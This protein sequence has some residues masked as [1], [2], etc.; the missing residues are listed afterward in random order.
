MPLTILHCK[1]VIWPQKSEV[2]RL[3]SAFLFQHVRTLICDTVFKNIV[4]TEGGKNGVVTL[5]RPTQLQRAKPTRCPVSYLDRSPQQLW[6]IDNRPGM[7][8][9]FIQGLV[10]LCHRV[11]DLNMPT[12]ERHNMAKDNDNCSAD[13]G[14]GTEVTHVI[15]SRSV[16]PDWLWGKGCVCTVRRKTP[17]DALKPAQSSEERRFWN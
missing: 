11:A 17:Q 12:L 9:K 14:T 5:P 6:C 8:G 16:L 1:R 13:T 4:A 3:R 2:L 7:K 10:P 15:H